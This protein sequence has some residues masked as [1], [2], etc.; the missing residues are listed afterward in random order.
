MYLKRERFI[1]KRCSCHVKNIQLSILYDDK[2]FYCVYQRLPSQSVIMWCCPIRKALRAATHYCTSVLQT[3]IHEKVCYI[4]IV[5][6]LSC[7]QQSRNTFSK[8]WPSAS[9]PLMHA[10]G[11]LQSHLSEFRILSVVCFSEG[12][13]FTQKPSF[14]AE[15]S[16]PSATVY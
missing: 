5:I 9:I 14:L 3:L 1:W 2:T 8:Y 12:R 4:V 16:L 15:D 6:Y 10:C 11:G 7:K 13:L